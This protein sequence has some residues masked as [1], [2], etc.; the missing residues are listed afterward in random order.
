MKP[1]LASD[2][3]LVPSVLAVLL[4]DGEGNRI[5][6]K[7]YQGFLG[8]AIEQ[9]RNVIFINPIPYAVEFRSKALQ[10]D[11]EYKYDEE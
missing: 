8:A 1:N 2:E 9:V 4:L 7:Y 6:A 10:E 11:E 5:I 3:S